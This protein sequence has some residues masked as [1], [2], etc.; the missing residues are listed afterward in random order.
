MKSP[1]PLGIHFPS[2]AVAACLVLGGDDASAATPYREETHGPRIGTRI[3]N[4]FKDLSYG[5]NPNDRYR[6]LPPRG[7]APQ[8]QQPYGG[9]PPAS[10]QRYSLDKP[11]LPYGQ[12]QR[13]QGPATSQPQPQAAQPP[14]PNANS[15][16]PT[17]SRDL[18]YETPPETPANDDRESPQ[19][20][21]GGQR[22]DL[23]PVKIKGTG[24]TAAAP[25]VAPDVQADK[26]LPP[27][28]KTDPPQPKTLPPNQV[29]DNATV[30]NKK[31][32]QSVPTE[33]LTPTTPV[34]TVTPPVEQTQPSTPATPPAGNNSATLTGSRTGKDGRVKSPYPPYNELDVSGLPTGS[35]AMDPTTGKVF[36]VP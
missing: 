8:P 15:A 26:K 27:P 35:L 33:G 10:S 23:P 20:G 28:V 32:W 21:I 34:T 18:P 25:R 2:L 5:Q 16:P 7:Y 29:A 6:N 4:F 30:N 17:A 24:T 3:L 22:E 31:A 12:P 36:R 9:R 19:A 11:P 1:L 14:A 13:P